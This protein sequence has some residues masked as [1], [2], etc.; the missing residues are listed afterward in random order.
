MH[1]HVR[2]LCFALTA[3]L[4]FAAHA[5]QITVISSFSKEVMAIYK[6]AFEKKNPDIKV[7]MVNKNT[8]AALKHI[9]ETV[10]GQR[11]EVFWASSPGAF[12]LLSHEKL[13]EK[14][15]ADVG[16][17]SVPTKIGAYPLND[18]DGFYKGQALSG[19]GM[20]WNTTYM[21]EKQLPTPNEWS[22]LTKP[23]YLGHI[24]MSSPSRSG[25]TH[26]TVETILQ[27]E[28]WDKGWS[29]L[30]QI[31]GNSAAIT[32]RSFDVPEGVSSGKYGVG[33]V[34]DYLGLSSKYSGS[35][36]E[37]IYPKVNAVVPANIG[38]I[39]G[40]KNIADA[41]KFVNFTLSKEGQELL[42]DPK[43]SRLP[44]LQ[45][46]YIGGKLPRDFPNVFQVARR[47]TVQFDSTVSEMRYPLVLALFDQT[48]T[49][50]FKELQ[51][52]TKAI[53]EAKQKLA[54]SSNQKAMAL[55][56]E[57]RELAYSP[58]VDEAT[59]NNKEFLEQ[60]K[61]AK[62]EASAANKVTPMEEQWS[63]KAKANYEKAAWNATQAASTV[64]E[65]KPVRKPKSDPK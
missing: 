28:G 59:L 24:A 39:A 13:L 25:T 48:I 19:Y 46:S 41:K 65:G 42:F 21:R 35:P 36:V 20:M 57:A 4:P 56:S 27:G 54:G 51:L 58:V 47:S 50:P 32:E 16:N 31:A 1:T 5:G 22:D 2:R 8:N 15:G 52:A 37:F 61:Q 11:P 6:D 55:L 30:L 53:H 18:P 7:E 43:I 63:A 45:E 14:L 17:P 10:V 26:L 60:F 64:K 12:E 33:L 49:G 34:I 62:K 3:I 29:Q 38:L 23:I 9:R 40:G 44:V